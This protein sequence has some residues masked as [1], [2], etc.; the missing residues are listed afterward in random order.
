MN[1]TTLEA[2]V[3]TLT[4]KELLNDDTLWGRLTARIRQDHE[5]QAHFGGL[6]G[7]D[8][9]NWSERILNET[10]GF[11]K[12]CSLDVGSFG[13]S[14]LVDIG[15]HTFMLYSRVYTD[16]C[17]DMCGMYIHHE[18]DDDPDIAKEAHT[19]DST[20]ETMSLHGIP[21]DMELWLNETIGC[22]A[23]GQPVGSRCSSNC[24][25]GGGHG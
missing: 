11:L 25:N 9:I 14:S 12:L 13:P 2:P 4:H 22:T 23:D 15:W 3:V 10:L 5:F 21:V 19:L 17:E 6:D 16:F 24:R 18:P 7:T 1:P 8:Q 20:V